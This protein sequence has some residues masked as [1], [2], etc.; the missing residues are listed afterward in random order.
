MRRNDEDGLSRTANNMLRDT[1]HDE[2]FQ[3][4]AAMGAEDDKIHTPMLCDSANLRGRFARPDQDFEWNVAKF[5]WLEKFV[6]LAFGIAARGLPEISQPIYA[7]TLV[8]EF[9][10]EINRMQDENFRPGIGRI[11]EGILQRMKRDGREIDRHENGRFA[12]VCAFGGRAVFPLPY[13]RPHDQDRTRRM[14]D[15]AFSGAAEHN[16][17]EAIVSM[18]RHDDQIDWDGLGEAADFVKDRGAFAKVRRGRRRQV[19]KPDDVGESF[20]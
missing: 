10:L 6:Q 1:A 18:C 12:L 4:G 9:V 19:M 8:A 2:M 16:M 3:T 17:F 15:D 7:P 5:R 14:L 13:L 11:S 20:A